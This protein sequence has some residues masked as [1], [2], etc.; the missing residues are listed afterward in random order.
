MKLC[1][2]AFVLLLGAQG[3]GG[4]SNPNY[5]GV[6]DYGAVTGRVIDAKTNQPV[7]SALVAVGSTVTATTDAQ[8]AFTL[9]QVPAGSQTVTVSAAGYVTTSQ[10]ASVKKDQTT[11]LDY[12]KLTAVQ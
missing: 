10:T 12:I 5:I 9:T 8:G 3:G 4:C 2:L 1:T 7:S 6:Q 11:Q